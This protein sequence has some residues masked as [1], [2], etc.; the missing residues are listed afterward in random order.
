[1]GRPPFEGTHMGAVDP[2]GPDP[3]RRACSWSNSRPCSVGQ[4]PASVLSRSR[5]QQVTPRA[6][7]QARGQLVPGGL[8]LGDEQD[9]GRGGTVID[10]PTPRITVTARLSAAAAERLAPTAR[11]RQAPRSP[12]TASTR[13]ADVLRRRPE[14]TMKRLLGGQTERSCGSALSGLSGVWSQRARLRR[15]RERFS[16]AKITATAATIVDA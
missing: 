6:T 3:A 16:R 12:T 13:P 11:R 14:V 2:T 9:A 1:M 4:T 7:G 8:V 5:R 10:R 15:Y